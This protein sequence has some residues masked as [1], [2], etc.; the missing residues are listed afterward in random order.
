[1]KRSAILVLF[2][3]LLSLAVLTGPAAALADE[4]QTTT[5]P[6]QKLTLFTAY[7]AQEIAIGENIVF[8]LTLRG[9][10]AP[11]VVRLE[12]KDMPA[13]RT[14]TF[15]STGKSVQAAYVDPTAA[16]SVELRLGPPLEVKAG[17]YHI[18]VMGHGERDELS[19]PI[20]LTVKEKLPPSMKF[21]VDLPTLRGTPSTTFRYNATLK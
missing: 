12:A 1:M 19:L 9:G 10:D 3:S 11:Q 7:P 18:T 20:E 2:I 4:N 8:S 21:N 14:A 5:T 15:R 17:D 16:T 6:P 13:R